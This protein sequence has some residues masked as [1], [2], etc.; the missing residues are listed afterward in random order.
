MWLHDRRWGSGIDLPRPE[1]RA[2]DIII[3]RYKGKLNVLMSDAFVASID[4][5]TLRNL[6]DEGLLRRTF[7][8][9]EVTIAGRRMAA[10]R[11]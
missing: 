7:T 10:K 4:L 8:G 6:K 1:A 11:R 3:H 9:Y 2:L 5:G